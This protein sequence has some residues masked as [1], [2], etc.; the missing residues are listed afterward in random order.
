[1]QI[2]IA[3]CSKLPDWEVD[4]VPFHEA[5][6]ERGLD[7]PHIAWDDSNTD[8]STFDAVLIRT[9][10]DY[11]ERQE[12]FLQWAQ[13]VEQVS[14]LFNPASIVKWNTHKSYLRD[15]EAKGVPIAPT[16]WLDQ[17]ATVDVK[18]VMTQRKWT[19]GFLKP[20]IG[21]TARETLR[22][23]TDEEGLHLAQAHVN[24]MLA[25]EDMLLQPYL[26]RVEADGEF[27]AI[28]IDG[29]ISHCVR[30]IPVE[31][32]YRV[33]D[34][35]GAKDERF[36]FSSEQLAIAKHVVEVVNQDLL[37]ARTDFLY[38]NDGRFVLTEFEAVEPSLF[39]RHNPEAADR[40]AEALCTR[41]QRALLAS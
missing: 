16:H 36:E 25:N 26:T 6:R 14:R 28:F 19:R 4:D 30:K 12:E 8:W 37:Y 22:F 24:R 10:W 38:D 7:V 20:A 39:F 33:Q 18:E 35:F 15:L 32:D 2:A 40:L 31:G 29:A 23:E 21:A 13:G 5:L 17:G 9:T 11:M 41:V 3:T 1:M 27:S 34:D